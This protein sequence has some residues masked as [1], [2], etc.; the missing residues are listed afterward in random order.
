MDLSYE[1]QRR[2]L[3]TLENAVI[4]MGETDSNEAEEKD[5]G[6]RESGKKRGSLVVR[7]GARRASVSLRIYAPI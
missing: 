7:H 5:R 1:N 3:S 6:S 2:L 4:Y